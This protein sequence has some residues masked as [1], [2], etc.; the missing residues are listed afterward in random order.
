VSRCGQPTWLTS[1][2]ALARVTSTRSPRPRRDRDRPPAPSERPQRAAART[3]CSLTRQLA[4]ARDLSS[5]RG[6]VCR[7]RPTLRGVT[8]PRSTAQLRRSTDGEQ[9][10][11]DRRAIAVLDDILGCMDRPQRETRLLP[12]A[13]VIEYVHAALSSRIAGRRSL[14]ANG[15]R[16]EIASDCAHPVVARVVLDL[17]Q[18]ECLEDRRH[19]VAEP[20]AQALLQ[21]IP[22]ATGL[23]GERPQAST[24]PSAA[25]FCSSAL[26]SA[27]SRVLLQ[28]LGGP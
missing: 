24:V 3:R 19:V 17:G 2:L 12:P 26:P 21:S 22:A 5:R 11:A 25:G 28:H 6:R 13:S 4:A 7:Q 14:A 10:N 20:A 23:S 9:G 27:S 18:A 8:A 16:S 15:W 1:P